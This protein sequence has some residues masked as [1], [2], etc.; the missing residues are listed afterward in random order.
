[1]LNVEMKLYI[2]LSFIQY[3]YTNIHSHL[4]LW[5]QCLSR[6]RSGRMQLHDAHGLESR[7]ELDLSTLDRQGLVTF[8]YETVSV[9]ND[10][11]LATK[12]EMDVVVGWLSFTWGLFTYQRAEG[13]LLDSI[14]PWNHNPYDLST[15][16]CDLDLLRPLL[17]LP[18]HHYCL[19]RRARH[20]QSFAQRTERQF[21]DSQA[22]V[23][24]VRVERADLGVGDRNSQ[25]NSDTYIQWVYDSV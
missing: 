7:G 3:K 24:A 19:A 18:L 22:G 25:F 4:P 6:S 9:A 1:M 12:Y 16:L 2:W 20:S 13:Q 17:S 14:W 5:V 21:L 10:V 11:Y 8:P 23:V 15:D